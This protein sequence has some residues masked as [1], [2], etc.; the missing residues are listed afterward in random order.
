MMHSSVVMAGLV[1]AIHVFLDK[2]QQDV[3]ARHKAGHDNGEA[4][5]NEANEAHYYSN[6]FLRQASAAL[7]PSL[8][9]IAS[10]SRPTSVVAA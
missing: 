10:N 1:P 8:A 4:G 9:L 3:D 7:R 2:A 5:A 6:C